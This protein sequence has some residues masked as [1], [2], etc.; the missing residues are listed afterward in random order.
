[1]SL[2]NQNQQCFDVIKGDNCDY[3]A[4]TAV[5]KVNAYVYENVYNNDYSDVDMISRFLIPNREYTDEK[6]SVLNIKT[7][8]GEKEVSHYIEYENIIEDVKRFS[9][10]NQPRRLANNEY[11]TVLMNSN[12]HT[13]RKSEGYYSMSTKKSNKSLFES[14]LRSNTNKK[15]N[16]VNDSGIEN[17]QQNGM[18]NNNNNNVKGCSLSLYKG[19]SFMEMLIQQ[20]KNKRMLNGNAVNVNATVNARMKEFIIM[21]DTTERN[22]NGVRKV[23]DFDEI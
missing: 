1:M 14:L 21:N 16:D 17:V 9:P 12:L 11:E 3:T 22:R 6:S 15:G 5:D 8:N 10:L 4:L 23:Y 13:Q 18:N 7:K 19:R 20:Q 2:I